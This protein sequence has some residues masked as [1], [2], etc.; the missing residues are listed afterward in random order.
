M[1]PVSLGLAPETN[2]DSLIGDVE[3]VLVICSIVGWLVAE[4]TFFE[5]EMLSLD[6]IFKILGR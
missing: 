3:F 1:E 4:R 2:K 5:H 6:S